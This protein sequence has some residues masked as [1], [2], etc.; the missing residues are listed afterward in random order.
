M[1]EYIYLF[2]ATLMLIGIIG[3]LALKKYRQSHSKEINESRLMTI[4]L[5]L[6]EIILGISLMYGATIVLRLVF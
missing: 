2:G 1:K 4:F 3:G 5:I 6:L